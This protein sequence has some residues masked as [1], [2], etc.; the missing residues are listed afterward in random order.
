MKIELF[1]LSFCLLATERRRKTLS[2]LFVKVYS[3]GPSTLEGHELVDS[4]QF[5]LEGPL[6]GYSSTQ[7]ITI[8]RPI[9]HFLIC[10]KRPSVHLTLALAR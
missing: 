10:L 8:V 3:L 5:P 7:P 6:L 4:G 9:G 1:Y 2:L